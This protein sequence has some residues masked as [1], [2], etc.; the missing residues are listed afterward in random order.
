VEHKHPWKQASASRDEQRSASGGRQKARLD[1]IPK[2]KPSALMRALLQMT[3]ETEETTER[4]RAP[5]VPS[6]N[7]SPATPISA[8]A[9]RQKAAR[10]GSKR[11]RRASFPSRTAEARRRR[12]L[13]APRRS[14]HIPVEQSEQETG[15]TA[16]SK[17]PTSLLREAHCLELDLA[18]ER[19]GRSERRVG[20]GAGGIGIRVSSPLAVG[21][22]LVVC[23]RASCVLGETLSPANRRR[24]QGL[25]YKK[26]R[27]FR[28]VVPGW[29]CP[30]TP[31]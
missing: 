11:D 15:F 18:E 1:L 20:A 3:M 16:G 29:W 21:R 24:R 14:D 28:S 8:A 30:G 19:A 31:F 5:T 7:F 22:Q 12:D 17:P 4:L 2:M 26:M 23:S 13:L 6:W 9:Y 25:L 10:N 27:H